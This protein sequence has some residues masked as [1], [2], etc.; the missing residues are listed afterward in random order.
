MKKLRLFFTIINR[1]GF[2]KILWS[3]GIWFII[4][5]ILMMVVEPDIHTFGESLW[6]TAVTCTSIGFGDFIAVTA[7]GRV[8]SIIIVV[9]EA[10]VISMLAG[11]VVSFHL[12][13]IRRLESETISM[14][15]E[16]LE[17]V[18]ELNHEELVDIENR[19]KKLK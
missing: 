17:R 16:K 13:I 2:D 12:E 4:T 5:T 6:Y 18:S 9:Y 15:L 10:I 14:F 11:V 3:F 19:V 1:V 8:L 7:F